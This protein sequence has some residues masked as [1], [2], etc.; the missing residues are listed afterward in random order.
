M[1]LALAVEV[2]SA[3]G[4]CISAHAWRTCSV[5]KPGGVMTWT[6]PGAP[7]EL[8]R[9]GEDDVGVDVLDVAVAIVMQHR[10]AG[11]DKLCCQ[12]GWCYPIAWPQTL[13]EMPSYCALLRNGASIAAIAR[14]HVTY[15]D[16]P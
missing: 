6:P 7:E 2:P 15:A 10:R 4:T 16:R 3:F 14:C 5:E 1:R 11:V 8:F 13:V 9:D 12:A